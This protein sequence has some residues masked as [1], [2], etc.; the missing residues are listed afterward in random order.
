[1][2]KQSKRMSRFWKVQWKKRKAKQD[3]LYERLWRI[4]KT[5]KGRQPTM[6]DIN[7]LYKERK[8]R[9]NHY[10]SLKKLLKKVDK[11]E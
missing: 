3:L 10:I 5:K 6:S 7:K 4:I 11:N 1:M 8:I 9:K 2:S